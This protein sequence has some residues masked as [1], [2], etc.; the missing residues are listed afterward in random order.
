[1]SGEQVGFGTHTRKTVK[2][3]D[4]QVRQLVTY[5]GNE[6]THKHIEDNGARFFTI[7]EVSHKYAKGESWKE[8]C[9]FEHTWHVD[10]N[11]YIPNSPLKRTRVLC[12]IFVIFL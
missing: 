9:G 12:T 6:Q 10:L 5:K 1:M 4:G 3:E 2:W 7:R 11:F 8:S